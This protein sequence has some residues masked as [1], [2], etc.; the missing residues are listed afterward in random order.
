MTNKP[1]QIAALQMVSTPSV[2]ENMRVARNLMQEAA[3][4]GARLVLLPEYF[5]LMGQQDTDKLAIAEAFGDGP[6]QTFLAE[7]AK[8]LGIY[9]VAGTIPLQSGQL[10]RVYNSSLVFNPDGQCTARYDKIHLFCFSKG[11]EQ[12]DE[13]RVLLPGSKPLVANCD[14]FKVG[15]SV[16]YD[17]RFPELYRAMGPVDLIVMPAAFTHTTGKAHWE[18]LMRARAIEN[19][20]Y[21]LACGQGGLHPTGRRTWGHSMVVDP[22]GEVER[23]LEEGE[24]VVM[25]LLDPAK[26]LDVRNSLPALTHRVL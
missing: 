24:G 5:C 12:Y 15:L 23:V 9:V 17:L 7:Q 26:M 22:W 1:M 19:Q 16:C 13:G 6:L 25:G 14:G 8:G 20:C 10:G 4:A 2:D 21:V 11:A 3:R 18:V